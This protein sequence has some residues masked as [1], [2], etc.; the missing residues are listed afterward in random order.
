ML[1]QHVGVF[2]GAAQPRACLRAKK[3]PSS[4]QCGWQVVLGQF[5]AWS[6]DNFRR[7]VAGVDAMTGS[8]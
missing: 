6:Q 1:A 7:I 4:N 2:V 3:T 5:R 8:M